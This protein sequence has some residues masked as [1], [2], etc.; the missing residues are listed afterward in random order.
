[1]TSSGEDVLSGAEWLCASTAAG[2]FEDPAALSGASPEW[3]PAAVPG[4]AAGALRAAG[5]WS[6]GHEDSALLDGRDWWFCTRFGA[7]QGEGPW[8]LRLGGL[9][10]LADVWLGDEH[11]AHHENMFAAVRIGVE[12]LEQVNELTIRCAALG[13][14]LERRHPRPRFKSRLVRH[15]ALRWYRTTLLGR[16]PGWS[17]W[18]A[19][20][21]PWR[22]VTLLARPAE[23]TLTDLE[24]TVR[25]LEG[26]G[27]EVRVGLL[28]RDGRRA[29]ESAVLDVDGVRTALALRPTAEGIR[30]GGQVTLEQVARWW[31]HTH[32]P[33]PRSTVAVEF[34]GVRRFER[35][36]GF[37]TVEL[38][39]ADGAFTLR[40]NGRECFCRGVT[41][42]PADGVSLTAE[43]REIA[44]GLDLVRRA[45]LNLIRLGGYGLYEDERFW[46]R[47]DELGIM[48]WQDCMIAS[49]DPPGDDGFFA[50]LSAELR[51][52]FGALQGRPALVMACGSSESY[53][54]GSML[55]LAPERYRSDVL[56]RRIPE[57]LA[58][59]V[60]GTPYVASSPSGGEPPIRTDEG[61]THYFGV[62]AYLRAPEDARLAG[63]RF[64]AECL[65][66]A[67]PPERE[68][69]ERVYGS[70]A[71]AGHDPRWKL[72]TARDA[73]TSWD[74]EDVRDHYVRELF[75]VDPLLVRYGD[76][77]HAL[78]LGRAAVVELIGRV[79]GDWRD[80]ASPC[81]GA[82]MLAWRDL[83]PGAGWGVLDSD[84][85]P[86]AV[87]HALA[88][89]S[90][91]CAVNLRDR[92]LNG[93]AIDVY[94]DG[95][96]PLKGVVRLSLFD[97]GGAELE[98][99]EHPVSVPEHGQRS[100]DGCTLLGGFWDL[101]A[102]YRFT[103][104]WPDAVLARLSSTEGELLSRRVFLPGGCA[105]PRGASTGLRASARRS[106]DETWSLTLSSERLAT[107]VSVDTPGLV[108]S[109]SWDHLAPGESVELELRGT[110]E[111]RGAVRALNSV[112]PTRITVESG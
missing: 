101:T 89:A 45:G 50:E 112:A 69:V 68:T 105:R 85:V 72:A 9:A 106:G 110:G 49:V 13:A 100:L 75:G 15:Q 63:V 109:A 41:W 64:A 32:G 38:D 16:M 111:P 65:S 37:R 46:E 56:E 24:L 62:G 73:G 59:I 61:V 90:A 14:R 102:A 71:A 36:I 83:W 67:N 74:F 26:G 40:V 25:C 66:F 35:R 42:G 33:Q 86:K 43:D 1:V 3:I 98:A 20:V 95:P 82:V 12:R 30:A 29:P 107:F 11:L 91:P 47:C 5:A 44:D 34:D 19:P 39:R 92:G 79:L 6:W 94:N 88:R 58:R 52:Q 28:L 10:T 48:V 53:Q 77:E 51:E 31:P 22:P 70:A 17:R 8:D 7:P 104:S 2:A 60:P 23:G 18:A 4:T 27:G 81:A 57:L 97:A 108:A 87:Y 54:Q 103:P 55:G 93:L 80:Q 96:R 21:G 78:D 99:A 76:P 84:G